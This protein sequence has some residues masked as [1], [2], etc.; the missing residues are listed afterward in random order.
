MP[1]VDPVVDYPP[2]PSA[3]SAGADLRVPDRKWRSPGRDR[4][5]NE[6]LE[7]SDQPRN[8]MTPPWPPGRPDSASNHPGWQKWAVTTLCRSPQSPWAWTMSNR[9]RT[10]AVAGSTNDRILARAFAPRRDVVVG[11]TRRVRLLERVGEYVDFV[12]PLEPGGQLGDIAAVAHM[13]VVVVDH[14]GDSQAA[15]GGGHGELQEGCYGVAEGEL[16]LVK[17]SA[18]QP[19]LG[20]PVR[21][22]RAGRATSRA[23]R[24]ESPAGAAATAPPTRPARRGRRWW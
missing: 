13:P 8:T 14:E 2:P 16:V 5:R 22:S 9:P 1:P 18:G 3:D 11:Q 7:R 15:V 19:Q 23:S 12:V 21:D 10:S 24:S 6:P 4:G 17:P 20:E